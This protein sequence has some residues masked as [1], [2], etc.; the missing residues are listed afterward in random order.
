MGFV[1]ERIR[2][3]LSGC[4]RLLL[5]SWYSFTAMIQLRSNLRKAL[6]THYLVNRSVS[7][8]VRELASLLGVDPTNLSRELHRLEVDGL[9]R[10]E[11]RDNQKYY[12]LNPKYPFLREVFTILRRTI[13]VVPAL[14]E[15]LRKIT[16]I[17]AAF[18][19]GPFAKG[20]ED[21]ASDIDV[22]ILGKPEA[23]E[24]AEATARLEKLLNREINYT[25]ITDKE[26]KRKLADHD[27]FVTDIW[28]GKRV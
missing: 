6:L 9:F 12:S 18:L 11:L 3:A 15:S 17:E 10:S 23:T 5:R 25:V 22:L 21:A 8:Y 20:E 1:G 13:G 26:L 2:L 24:L 7:H 16:G 4:G 19:Y 27:P 14:A 28:K